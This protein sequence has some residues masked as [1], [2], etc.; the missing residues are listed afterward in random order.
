MKRRL[1]TEML[2]VLPADDPAAVASRR[3]L[4]R[5]NAVMRQSAILAGALRTFAQPH[6]LLDL[7]GGDGRCLLAAARRLSWRGV[8]AVIADRQDIVSAKTRTGFAALGW[9]CVVRQGDVFD[10]AATMEWGTLVSANLFL[11]HLDDAALKRLFALLAEKAIGL[12]ACE[13]RRG[14]LAL[15]ASHLVV[16][17]GANEVTR[18]DAIASVRAGFAA[19]ELTALWPPGWTCLEGRAL[20]FSHLFVARRYGI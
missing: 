7:G 3:D 10:A 14:A 2:D 8:R 5:I 16:L 20:P 18:H 17:L 9:D 19:Q 15:L 6:V 12:V 1:E 4:A 11:H 13:P